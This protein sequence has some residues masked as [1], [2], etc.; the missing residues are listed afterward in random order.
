MRTINESSPIEVIFFRG[1]G[2]WD[3][4]YGLE[5]KI[6]EMVEAANLQADHVNLTATSF[7][8]AWDKSELFGFITR[9][10]RRNKLKSLI[11]KEHDRLPAFSK[12]KGSLKLD[13]ID[14]NKDIVTDVTDFLLRPGVA[15]DY[16]DSIRYFAESMARVIMSSGIGRNRTRFM[17]VGHSLGSVGAFLF[18]EYLKA[19]F[20]PAEWSIYEMSS[21]LSLKMV[22]PAMGFPTVRNKVN[23]YTP[24]TRQGGMLMTRYDVITGTDD[25]LRSLPTY[26][27]SNFLEWKPAPRTL[28]RA[29]VE[30]PFLNL[31]HNMADYLDTSC[32]TLRAAWQMGTDL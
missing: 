29:S 13:A 32:Q 27:T 11:K 30:L 6:V 8:T 3:M 21:R 23:R 14:E 26:S 17:V 15:E 22:V 19:Q 10:L 18:V 12:P 1:A 25:V 31:T 5:N 24:S 4:A 2:G 7:H 20:S 28:A 16:A 9:A